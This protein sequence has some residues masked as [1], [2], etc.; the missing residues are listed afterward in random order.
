MKYNINLPVNFAVINLSAQYEKMLWKALIYL[1]L[2]AMP[3]GHRGG[4]LFVID[5]I[6][7]YLSI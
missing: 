1:P 6:M 4:Q 5:C 2:W 7:D 3:L